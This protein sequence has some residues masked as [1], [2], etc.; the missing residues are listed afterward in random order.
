MAEFIGVECHHAADG[1][2]KVRRIQLGAHWMPVGQGRQWLDESGRHVLVITPQNTVL[3]IVQQPDTLKWVVA[4]Q[5]DG[6]Q[7]I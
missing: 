3:E 7:M 4:A 5:H 1:R 2:V 6:T